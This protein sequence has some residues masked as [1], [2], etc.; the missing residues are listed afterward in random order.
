MYGRIL[1][2][3]LLLGMAALP[4]AVLAVDSSV[5]A[6]PGLVA[7]PGVPDL[8]QDKTKLQW[9]WV[10]FK[11]EGERL[12]DSGNHEEAVKNF[13]MAQA[14]L[15]TE[16]PARHYTT[17][18]S[19]A[20]LEYD[21]MESYKKWKGHSDEAERSEQ[22]FEELS[23]S[24]KKKMQE[25]SVGGGGCLIVTATFGSPLAAEVQLVRGFRDNSITKSYTGSR[26]MPGFN[27]W[28]YSFSPQVADYI[29]G[30][31]IVKPA[32]QVLITPI[33]EIV[34]LAQTV[35]N[36]LSFSPELATIAA[37]IVGSTLYGLIYIFPTVMAG[38]WV[39]R[40]R[41]WAGTGIRNLWPAAAAWGVLLVL[42]AAG[43]AFS[44]DLLTTVA[45]GLFVIATIILVVASLSVS[46]APYVGRK[47]A[48]TQE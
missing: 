36:L 1:L 2:L 43:V 8:L 10:Q 28:Y 25:E 9:D 3:V 41:G 44:F 14:M 27:A 45:S 23:A 30:H 29:R 33:L 22:K 6:A 5:P 11:Q 47:S 31:P 35:W 39:A 26:F 24:A 42:I 4:A 20:T 18:S 40:R 7:L 16:D 17:E 32:M 46:L 15:L 21:K 12:A 38:V 13:K 48:A 34:L 19:L 37:I